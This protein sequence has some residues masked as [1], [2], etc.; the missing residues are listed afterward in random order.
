MLSYTVKRFAGRTRRLNLPFSILLPD[1][2]VMSVIDNL[3]RWKCAVLT[4]S[5]KWADAICI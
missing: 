1:A 4:P 3:G 2:V 5:R